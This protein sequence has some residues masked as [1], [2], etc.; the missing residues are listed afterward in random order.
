[1]KTRKTILVTGGAGFIGANLCETLLM[2]GHKVICLDNFYIKIG[3]TENRIPETRI[4]EQNG[5]I[6]FIFK[7]AYNRKLEHLV[8]LFFNF[9]NLTRVLDGRKQ[10]EWFHFK[11]S[12]NILSVVVQLNDI[13]FSLF[14]G[15]NIC[16]R[17]VNINYADKTELM[18]LPDIG[19]KLSK[20]PA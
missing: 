8:H 15:K 9:A 16:N 10:T 17:K 14:G 5:E 1:M 2:Q 19:I 13:I 7:A 4:L 18:T 12:I 3:R 20:T 11:E 6:N